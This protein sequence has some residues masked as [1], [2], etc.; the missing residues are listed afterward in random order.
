V[1]TRAEVAE[2]VWCA[3]KLK[4]LKACIVCAVSCEFMYP[5]N[6]PITTIDACLQPLSRCSRNHMPPFKTIEAQRCWAGKCGRGLMYLFCGGHS[7]V[8]RL[9]CSFVFC[10][11]PHEQVPKNFLLARAYTMMCVFWTMHITLPQ[12]SMYVFWTMHITLPPVSEAL[13]HRC[14][15]AWCGVGEQCGWRHD[16]CGAH[17]S[18]GAQQ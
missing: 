10:F 8:D 9:L 2:S 13:C 7:F 11:S 12:V 4:L 17:C 6:T 1:C 18:G 14:S 3:I 15:G 16:V 5:L